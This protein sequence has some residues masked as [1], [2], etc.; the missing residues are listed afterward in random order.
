MEAALAALARVRI[1]GPLATVFYLHF[2]GGSGADRTIDV[3]DVIA[4]DA[5]YAAGSEGPS[6]A[7]VHPVPPT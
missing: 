2:F 1:T 4:R 7:V 3:A 6:L 5:G